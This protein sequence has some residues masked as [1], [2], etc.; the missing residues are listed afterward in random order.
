MNK[1]SRIEE[2]ETRVKL[3]QDD[4]VMIAGTMEAMVRKRALIN[5]EIV[6]LQEKIDALVITR[7]LVKSEQT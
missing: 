6:D 3:L 1:D 2:L 5:L 4:L 7:D